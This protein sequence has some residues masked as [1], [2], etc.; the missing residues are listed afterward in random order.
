MTASPA[1]AQLARA[2]FMLPAQHVH[3]SR[4]LGRHVSTQA[5]TP[6]GLAR[7]DDEGGKLLALVDSGIN[8]PRGAG[9]GLRLLAWGFALRG[10][11]EESGKA[12]RTWALLFDNL[13]I[14]NTMWRN[15]G[16]TDE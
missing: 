3:H 14:L 16:I 15:H 4:S 8:T 11:R 7:G 1:L 12:L 6:R 10:I 5:S 13:K 9:V 2:A